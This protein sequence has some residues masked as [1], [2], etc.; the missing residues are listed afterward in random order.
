[1]LDVA[2]TNRGARCEFIQVINGEIADPT[3]R[4]HHSVLTE[5]ELSKRATTDNCGYINLPNPLR[6]FPQSEKIV[7]PS[8]YPGLVYFRWHQ[9]TGA[10]SVQWGDRRNCSNAPIKDVIASSILAPD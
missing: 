7:C 4:A 8:P 6:N 10:S 5:T 2:T 3:R 1:M 9:K